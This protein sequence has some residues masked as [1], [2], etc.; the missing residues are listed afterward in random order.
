[1]LRML[2]GGGGVREPVRRRLSRPALPAGI[3]R[4]PRFA[5]ETAYEAVNAACDGA[6]Y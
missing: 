5:S 6:E 2:C 4:S 1:M 3:R